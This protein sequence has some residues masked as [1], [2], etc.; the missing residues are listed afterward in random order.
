MRLFPFVIE[1]VALA[2]VASAAPF[3][4]LVTA[5][6]NATSASIAQST[7]ALSLE[8]ALDTGGF[9]V[10]GIQFQVTTTASGAIYGATPITA[11]ASPFVAGD[12]GLQPAAS[13]ALDASPEISFFKAAGADYAPRRRR[14]HRPIGFR[15]LDRRVENVHVHADVPAVLERNDRLG[16]TR[17]LRRPRRLHS[18]RRAGSGADRPSGDVRVRRRR[19]GPPQSAVPSVPPRFF[20]VGPIEGHSVLPSR[21]SS[22]AWSFGIRL[23]NLRGDSPL[24]P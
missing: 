24:R 8:V 20:D 19:Y 10:S 13:A 4:K 17:R 3:L 16:I 23:T 6:G 5:G 12:L 15:T 18:D 11:M 1:C 9:P 14:V 2:P 21:V 22:A 7:S